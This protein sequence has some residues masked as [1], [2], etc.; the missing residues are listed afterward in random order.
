M[1]VQFVLLCRHLGRGMER[2]AYPTRPYQFLPP[3]LTLF[4][5][6]RIRFS[7]NGWD[8]WLRWLALDLHHRR[9]RHF[10]LR[11]RFQ[12]LHRRLA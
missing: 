12:I 7:E 2:G 1:E 10:P 5:A 4:A 9:P 8:R 6:S 3:S 11:R